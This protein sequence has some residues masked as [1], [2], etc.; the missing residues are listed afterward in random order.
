LA[1][2]GEGGKSPGKLH[3]QG[4]MQFQGKQS[5][6]GQRI[7]NMAVGKWEGKGRGRWRV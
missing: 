4:W 2:W 7:V 1:S 6:G 5:D 3:S